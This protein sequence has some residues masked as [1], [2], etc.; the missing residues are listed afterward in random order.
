VESSRPA[1]AEDIPRVVELARQMR[2]ELGAMRGGALWVEREAWP[3][4]LEDAY[5]ALVARDDA[6]LLLGT[7]DDVVVGFAA[8]VVEQLR[9]GARLGVITDL[10]V[11]PEAREVGVGEALADALVDHCRGAG[12]IG[13]DATALPGHRAAKNFFEA[14]GFTARALA[15]HRRLDPDPA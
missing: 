14:H 4:P 13:V 3:E 5:D 1:S 15:M 10:Y 9:S 8:V 7:I 2:A 11:E 6:R 12:C